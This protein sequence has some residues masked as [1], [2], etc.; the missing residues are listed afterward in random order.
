MIAIKMS[1]IMNYIKKNLMMDVT[2]VYVIKD[3]AIQFL[4]DSLVLMKLIGMSKM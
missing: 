4:E 1:L 2:F 3:I